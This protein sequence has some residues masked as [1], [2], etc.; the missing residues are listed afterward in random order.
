MLIIQKFKNLVNFK[1]DTQNLSNIY[2][3]LF[4]K[5]NFKKN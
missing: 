1:T 5:Q 4:F 2:K 3:V